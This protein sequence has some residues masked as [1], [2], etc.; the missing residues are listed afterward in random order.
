MAECMDLNH[1][2]NHVA[3]NEGVAHASRSLYNSIADVAHREN[4]GFATRLKDSVT[5]FVNER[6]EVES[7]RVP[8]AP[9]AFYQHLRLGKIFFC[10]VHSKSKGVSLMVVRAEFLA[11]QLPLLACHPCSSSSLGFVGQVQC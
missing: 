4:T 10:P 5:D 9:R 6:S 7:A 11:A 8:H 3:R 1:R 2:S